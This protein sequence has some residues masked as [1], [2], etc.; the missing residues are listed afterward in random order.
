[1]ADKLTPEQRSACMRSVRGKDTAPELM[2][3]RLVHSMGFR[4]ALHSKELPGKPD[5]VLVSRKKII[6]VHG[7]FWHLHRCR[8][9]RTAPVNNSDYWTQKRMR[10]AERDLQNI[11]TLRQAG[12]DVLIVWECWIKDFS[13]LH[14]KINSFLQE[15]SL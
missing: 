9:G 13:A 11:R 6:F 10:N 1:V 3:R 7:C 8:H 12:W 14:K 15:T 5:I 4:Y 2:V